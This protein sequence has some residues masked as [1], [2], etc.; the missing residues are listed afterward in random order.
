MMM[1]CAEQQ[2]GDFLN[3]KGLI[4]RVKEILNRHS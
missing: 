3:A 4:L 1:A 2:V